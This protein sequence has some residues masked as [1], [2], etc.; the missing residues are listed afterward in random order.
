MRHSVSKNLFL[1]FVLASTS[2]GLAQTTFTAPESG[3]QHYRLMFT[4]STGQNSTIEQSLTLDVPVSHGGRGTAK[5][6]LA[7]GT[8]GDA[9]SF[10]QQFLECTDVHPS[11]TGLHVSI[12]TQSD[13]KLRLW[14]V[15]FRRDINMGSFSVKQIW[16]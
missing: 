3:I 5:I 14:R 1:A 15:S 2:A 9:Q 4:V 13:R 6:S 11:A 16:S 12:T 10:V 7:S 8:E